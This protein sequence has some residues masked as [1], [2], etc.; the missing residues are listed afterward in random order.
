MRLCT[1]L[2]RHPCPAPRRPKDRAVVVCKSMN[3]ADDDL[4]VF[5]LD[6]D[7]D[8]ELTMD[9]IKAVIENSKMM[10]EYTKD[11]YFASYNLDYNKI[12]Q[13]FDKVDTLEKIVQNKNRSMSPNVTMIIVWLFAY[14]MCLYAPIMY[15]ILR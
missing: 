4:S 15:M 2:L 11:I 12:R 1:T 13:Y 5:S 7:V 9:D 6:H 10:D 3:D 14:I 8:Y